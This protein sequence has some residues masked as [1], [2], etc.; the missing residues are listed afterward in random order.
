MSRDA[1]LNSEANM[2]IFVL[3][4]YY[5][6]LLNNTYDKIIFLIFSIRI[7]FR[8]TKGKPTQQHGKH[9]KSPKFISTWTG[10]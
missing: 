1:V 2:V 3:C 5:I 8:Y 4:I 9:G 10:C 6:D 7:V